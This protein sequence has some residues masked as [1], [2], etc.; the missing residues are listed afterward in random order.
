MRPLR[1]AAAALLLAGRAS[2]F[3]APNQEGRSGFST[4]TFNHHS[5]PLVP[6]STSTRCVQ[7]PA[8]ASDCG[9]GGAVVSGAPSEAAKAMDPRE[10]IGR[11]TFL[12]LNGEETNM[13][14]LIGNTGT[15]LVVFLR[16]LG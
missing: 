5:I 3:V 2:A 13:N 8:T 1:G 10:A 14:Q 4:S 16:S 15:S 6:A 9:C 7:L 11:S 12:T